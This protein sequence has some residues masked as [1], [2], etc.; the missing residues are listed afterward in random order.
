[1]RTTRRH[2]GIFRILCTQTF[3]LQ[4]ALKTGIFEHNSS[5]RLFHA[6][7]RNQFQIQFLDKCF[8]ETH[9]LL[10]SLHT[11]TG[12]PWVLTLPLTALLIRGVLITP[13]TI[14]NIKNRQRM[15]SL[16]PI[17]DAWSHILQRK[18]NEEHGSLGPEKAGKILKAELKIKKGEL[19]RTMNVSTLG[20]YSP[21]LQFPVWLLL[22][23]TIRKMS[24]APDGLLSLL[25]KSFS[26]SVDQDRDASLVA[27][28]SKFPVE[29]SFSTE[30]AL[31]FSNLLVPDPQLILPF[32]LSGVLFANIYRQT[33]VANASGLA[34]GKWSKR[35]SNS[36][37]VVALAIGPLTLQIPAC[38]SFKTSTLLTE[39]LINLM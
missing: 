6:T 33:Q 21:W 24:G 28:G 7:H 2:F 12:L 10:A 30:G 19:Y 15:A 11:V 16:S 39:H 32:I 25:A 38:V 14:Y 5:Q 18:V 34:L 20:L 27:I 13:L 4:P 36:L 31:W 26:Q 3:R 37:K 35:L 17:L 1:M 29:Q 9:N 23:E 8:S 22:I